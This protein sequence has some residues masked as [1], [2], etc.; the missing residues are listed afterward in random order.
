[1]AASRHRLGAVAMMPG[2]GPPTPGPGSI[3]ICAGGRLLRCVNLPIGGTSVVL[4]LSSPYGGCRKQPPLPAAIVM[5]SR[6]EAM[7]DFMCPPQEA[8]IPASSGQLSRFRHHASIELAFRLPRVARDPACWIEIDPWPASIYNSCPRR[9]SHRHGML[10]T[11]D[12]R[13][14]RVA[15][16]CGDVVLVGVLQS[17]S[18]ANPAKP[19]HEVHFAHSSRGWPLADGGCAT[20]SGADS[21]AATAR[22][23]S[24]GGQRLLQPARQHARATRLLRRVLAAVDAQRSIAAKMRHKVDLLGQPTDRLGHL[25][26]AG[27][28]SRARCCGS[29]SNCRAVNMTSTLRAGLRRR[30]TCGSMKTLGASKTLGRVDLARLRRARPKS[31]GHRPLSAGAWLALG[32]LPKL[33]AS[34][35]GSFQFAPA[36][37]SRLDDAAGVDARR[38][39]E[40][41]AARRSC[42][43]IRKRP[44]KPAARPICQQADAQP[45]RSSRAARWLRRPFS[46]P[47]RILAQR[48]GRQG[49][50]EQRAARSCWC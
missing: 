12:V 4:S 24:A 45:A 44:S 32:G 25:P 5:P 22:P 17:I 43:R 11:V 19:E 7:R 8:Q 1:M 35:E 10:T 47:D 26:A 38:P 27:Q 9:A 23:A 37:E 13:R 49:R 42:C 34:L 29:S 39:L 16:S 50:Q 15:S 46:L 6:I 30:R 28:G 2:P 48:A 21:R 20:A 40:A 3:S 36:A 18:L 14:S 31:P 33:L 41:A